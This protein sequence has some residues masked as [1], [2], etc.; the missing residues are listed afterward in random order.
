MYLANTLIYDF[1]LFWDYKS[2]RYLFYIGL[3]HQ[4]NL[5]SIFP[6][7]SYSYLQRITICYFLWDKRCVVYQQLKQKWDKSRS[8]G[9]IFINYFSFDICSLRNSKSHML[10]NNRNCFAHCQSLL[11]RDPPAR[12]TLKFSVHM[13]VTLYAWFQRH[14]EYLLCQNNISCLQNSLRKNTARDELF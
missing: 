6:G 9:T 13:A 5:K 4:G 10:L 14:Q 3:C 7:H 12:I 2:S 11:H 8:H 1:I